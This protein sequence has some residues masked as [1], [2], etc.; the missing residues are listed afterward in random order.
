MRDGQER[1]SFPVSFG[2][3]PVSDKVRAHDLTTPEGRYFIVYA[4]RSPLYSRTL[5]LSYPDLIDAQHGLA[6]GVLSAREYRRIAARAG[7]VAPGPCGTA[8]GCSIV[9]HGGGVI[10]DGVR[11]WTEGC[12]ALDNDA[13]RFLAAH[14]HKGDPVIILNSGRSLYRLLR[15]FA[16]VRGVDADG[17]PACPDGI[18][19]YEARL[20]TSLGDLYCRIREG[21]GV[22]LLIRVYGQDAS[23]PVLE[24]AD[25]NADGHL[26][27]L[28]HVRGLL[29]AG[30]SPEAVQ[31]RIHEAVVR[32]LRA[33]TL[34]EHPA[35][36]FR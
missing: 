21:E 18:C 7:R 1:A 14:C 30:S 6:S 28:D 22:S 5:G 8:L 12:V 27:Y 9:L 15:P 11:D 23:T 25:Q 10:R 16:A 26:S 29:A 31:A 20:A 3:D 36:A 13:M 17:L 2:L 32:A 34:P 35:R 19:V 33:G 24:L 4:L